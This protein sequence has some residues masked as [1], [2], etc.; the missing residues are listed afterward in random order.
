MSSSKSLVSRATNARVLSAGVCSF[1][2]HTERESLSQGWQADS[3]NNTYS[4]WVD[5]YYRKPHICST[6]R[7]FFEALAISPR[8]AIAVRPQKKSRV[9]QV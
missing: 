3:T 8:L 4:T 7:H 9:A 1:P 5:V 2:A 6:L